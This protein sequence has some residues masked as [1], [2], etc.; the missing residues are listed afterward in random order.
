[1][2]INRKMDKL[3]VIYSYNRILH[4][5]KKGQITDIHN[6]M[7]KSQRDYVKQKPD[8]KE[9]IPYDSIYM[10]FKIKQN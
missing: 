1:M 6:N 7:G 3:I 4:S 8:T 5:N 2:S 9:Y 10:K